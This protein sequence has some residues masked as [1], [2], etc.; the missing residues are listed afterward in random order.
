MGGAATEISSR[1]QSGIDRSGAVRSDLGAAHVPRAGPVQ[2]VELPFRAAARPRSHRLGQQALLRADPESGRRHA[3][4]RLIDIGRHIT[5]KKLPIRLRL[6]QIAR[7]LG[8]EIDR[9]EVV[10]ILKALGLEEESSNGAAL[11]FRPPSWRSDLE[12]EIDL[13]EE[14]ARVHGYEH[15]PEDRPVAVSSS[16]RGIRERVESALRQILAGAG[17][18]EAVTYSLV[19]DRL[20]VPVQP[21]EPLPPLRVDHSSRKRESA[22][23]QSLIPSLLAAR[24][25][26]ETHGLTDADLFEIANVYQARPASGAAGGT[27]APGAGRRR[28]FPNV[29]RGDRNALGGPARCCAAGDP[30]G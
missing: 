6:D 15:I 27:D 4:P 10:R 19:E 8:I 13:I 14:V 24:L 28:R 1:T 16:P 3:S 21:G 26:N 7:V 22:L 29:E 23:R 11:G 25:H 20:A 5:A 2:S 17:F 12:R 18:D 9:A 30:A